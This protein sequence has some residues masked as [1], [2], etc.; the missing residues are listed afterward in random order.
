MSPFIHVIFK[1]KKMW[2]QFRKIEKGEFLLFALD[3]SS[4]GGDNTTCQALSKTKIDVPLVYKSPES[5]TVFIPILHRTL[6]AIF[7]HTGV[8]PCVA[9]ERNNGGNFLMDRLAA[10]NHLGKY[11][12]FLMPDFGKDVK[13][14]AN[15]I[16][17][18]FNVVLTNKFGWDTNS[19][20]RDKALQELQEVVE[21]K[22]LIIYDKDTLKE[23]LSF[24][25]KN[26]R[27]EA[28]RGSHD[29]L[30]LALAIAWQMY[31]IQP[32]P[33]KNA[34]FDYS[35]YEDYKQPEINY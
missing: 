33:S 18:G 19:S 35:Q 10:M 9:F 27:P 14:K 4:G 22:L 3:T 12:I 23:L 26:G 5:T 17:P 1:E 32:I 11:D 21:K 6:E 8:K 20:T 2:K 30:V 7:D 13:D 29:D 24:V 34:D 25:K 16:L 15:K 31:L 28:E